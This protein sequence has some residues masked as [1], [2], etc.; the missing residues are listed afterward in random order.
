MRGTCD[1]DLAGLGGGRAPADAAAEATSSPPNARPVPEFSGLA[2]D[3]DEDAS[4]GAARAA[5]AGLRRVERA[6]GVATTA[7]LPAEVS[8]SSSLSSAMPA[9]VVDATRDAMTT[10]SERAAAALTSAA[11]SACSDAS[12]SEHAS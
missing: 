8:A 5:A 6:G 2:D 9:A 4:A 7:R 10:S 12:L 11:S 3:E 1:T